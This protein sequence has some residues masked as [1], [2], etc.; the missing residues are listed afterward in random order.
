MQKPFQWQQCAVLLTIALLHGGFCNAQQIDL[1]QFGYH[2]PTGHPAPP[3]FSAISYISPDTIFVTFAADHPETIY[4]KPFDY[5]AAILRKDGSQIARAVLSGFWD[6]QLQRRFSIQ[7]ESKVLIVVADDLRIYDPDLKSFQTSKLPDRPQLRLSPDRKTILILSQ[8]GN[9]AFA[10]T[11]TLPELTIASQHLSFNERAVRDAEIAVSNKGAIAHA[12]RDP[13]AELSISVSQN[14]WPPEFT[15]G[16]HQTPLSFIG[17]DQLL[18]SA[19]ATTPFPSTYLYIW[20]S[21]G[22]TRKIRSTS[23]GF[24]TGAQSSLDGNRV[25]VTYTDDNFFLEMLGG[26]DCGDCGESYY[27]SVVDIPSTKALFTHRQRWNCME[28]LSP[29]GK[30]IAELCDGIVR[31]IEIPDK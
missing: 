4:G 3:A 20:K 1:A 22:S 6:D 19:M 16:K 14:R 9:E 29:N 15:I 13:G 31:F 24:Y 25:L 18:V 30:E 17:E 2:A 27:Y 8:D 26:F 23:A 12:V 11:I 7:P 21:D 5:N 10:K 28:A